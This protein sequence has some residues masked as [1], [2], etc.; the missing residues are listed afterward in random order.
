MNMK[1][2][3]VEARV[4]VALLLGKTL[5]HWQAWKRFKTNRLASYINR[6]RNKGMKIKTLMVT[7]PEGG[8][9]GVYYLEQKEKVSRI[10]TT[11]K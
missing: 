1:P 10:K 2:N 11:L 4:K 8:Q 9:Y 5:T 6:L 7:S 3:Q